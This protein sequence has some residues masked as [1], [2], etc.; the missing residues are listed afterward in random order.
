MSGHSCMTRKFNYC[1]SLDFPSG[2]KCKKSFGNSI[3]LRLLSPCG[4]NQMNQ[5]I[6]LLKSNFPVTLDEKVYGSDYFAFR[7]NSH[8]K[9]FSYCDSFSKV[10]IPHFRGPKIFTVFMKLIF[11]PMANLLFF[12]CCFGEGY[13][14]SIM[15]PSH[16]N[17]SVSFPLQWGSSFKFSREA[18]L[19]TS[20]PPFQ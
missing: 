3:S 15:S 19:I 10:K 8:L 4:E 18:K 5:I 17:P 11:I 14:F 7:G 6:F 20:L 13:V 9:K 2:R 12:G 1:I 16:W